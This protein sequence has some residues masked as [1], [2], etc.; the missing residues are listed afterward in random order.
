MLQ[1]RNSVD[2]TDCVVDGA[3]ESKEIAILETRGVGTLRQG[4]LQMGKKFTPTLQKHTK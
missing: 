1:D 2:L 4:Q 3:S